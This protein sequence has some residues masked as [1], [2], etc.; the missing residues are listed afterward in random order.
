MEDLGSSISMT[1]MCAWLRACASLNKSLPSLESGQNLRCLQFCEQQ[2]M[3]KDTCRTV[4]PEHSRPEGPTARAAYWKEL[5]HILIREKP[6]CV[7]GAPPNQRQLL[8]QH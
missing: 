6:Y 4:W 7:Q 8:L 2:H 5:Q 3:Q 1:S